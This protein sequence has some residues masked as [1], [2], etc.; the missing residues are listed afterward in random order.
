MKR[1]ALVRVGGGL[2]VAL[3]MAAAPFGGAGAQASTGVRPGAITPATIT[4]VTFTLSGDT[5]TVTVNGS[6]FGTLP[7]ADPRTPVA[8]TAGS[9]GYDYGPG[10][11]WFTDKSKGWTAGQYKPKQHA[12]YDCIGLLVSEF[13]D[14]QIVFAFGSYYGVYGPLQVGDKWKLHVHGTTAT[15]KA[16]S[17]TVAGKVTDASTGKPV[18]GECVTI[19]DPSTGTVFATAKP[20]TAT[21][22]Y[23]AKVLP[24][25]ALV[26]EFVDCS[27][28]S[29]ATTWSGGA[30]YR[31][32][33]TTFS[34]TQGGT[35]TLNQPVQP[36][37]T[38]TGTVTFG[39]SGTLFA[40]GPVTVSFADGPDGMADAAAFTVCSDSSG[41]YTA[42]GLP[43]GVDLKISVNVP[44]MPMDF[45]PG[46]A[47]CTN[48][49][50]SFFYGWY[51]A[52][53]SFASADTIN[54]TPAGQTG[55]NI[56][57]V[58]LAI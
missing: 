51:Q 37:A 19:V 58:D 31:T 41:N 5:P 50:S 55:V 32:T 39:G 54:L 36:G 1:D 29:Y 25:P 57:A 28:G 47:T 34:V 53:G 30:P 21:G 35:T 15:G 16:A 48:T 13:T 56:D 9:T 11:L 14:T 52:A 27:G 23:S 10:G 12:G 42:T 2:I 49:G 4:S 44:G 40:N 8:C 45:A 43:T 3:T 46:A 17:G 22:H 24:D 6:G 20:T 7:K 18:A 33:A 38:I 26:A